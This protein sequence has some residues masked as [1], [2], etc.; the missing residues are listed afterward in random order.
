MKILKISTSF[1]IS[2]LN[3]ICNKVISIGN[4]PSHLKYSAVKHLYE[5]VIKRC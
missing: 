2:P 5:K 3:Y 4:F 1:I